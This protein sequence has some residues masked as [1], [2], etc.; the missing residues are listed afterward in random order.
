[1]TKILNEKID[2]SFTGMYKPNAMKKAVSMLSNVDSIY[3]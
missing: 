1:M 3:G 2:F